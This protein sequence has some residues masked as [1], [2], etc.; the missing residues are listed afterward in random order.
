MSWGKSIVVAMTLFAAFIATLVTICMRQDISLVTR[1]YYQQEGVFQENL[2]AAFNA[3]ALPSPPQI[4]IVEHYLL[5]VDVERIAEME[6]AELL[7]FSPSTEKRDR[8][9]VLSAAR[10]SQQLFDISTLEPGMYRAR[11]SWTMQ[12]KPYYLEKVVYR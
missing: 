5:K 6:N 10:R 4:E 2:V 1:D 7:L 8:R 12:G 11:L 9:F 3:S